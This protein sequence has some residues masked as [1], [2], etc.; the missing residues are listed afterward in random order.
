MT[1]ECNYAIA[2][3]TLGDWFKNLVPVC[4]P[5]RRNTKTNRHLHARFFPRFEQVTW[6]WY[7]FGLVHCAVCALWLVEVIYFVICFTT[8]NWKLLHQNLICPRNKFLGILKCDS[9]R[10]NKKHSDL[11]QFVI[12]VTQGWLS[13]L[14]FATTYQSQKEIW[15]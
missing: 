6:N 14:K 8:L 4:Q 9:N 10:E 13:A 3:A 1:D 5:M 2:I 15:H 12:F 11:L 7:E